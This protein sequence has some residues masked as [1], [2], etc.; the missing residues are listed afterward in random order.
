MPKT[1]VSLIAATL[2]PVRSERGL[3]IMPDTTLADAPPLDVVF[4]PGGI[5][6]NRAMEDEHLLVWLH[7]QAA[8]ARYVTAVCTGAL[9]LGAAGL[10]RGYRATTHWLSLDLLP[11]FGAQPHAERVV[12]DRNRITGGGVTAGIDFGLTVAAEIYGKEVAEEIQLVLEYDP[13]PPFRSGS[14]R[15]A[16]ADL[17]EHMRATRQSMQDQRRAIVERAQAQLQQDK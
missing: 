1:H 16:S 4:M 14:P 2:A 6:V 8:Q 7:K 13:Q 10:L 9:V 3:A 11:L 17:V 15:T 12:I 5:G